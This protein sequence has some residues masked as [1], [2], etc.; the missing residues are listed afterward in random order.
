MFK[1]I[2]KW[3]YENQ[4]YEKYPIP[5]DWN[6]NIYKDNMEEIVNCAYCGKKIRVGDN[7]ESLEIRNQDYEGYIICEKCFNKEMLRR[8]H[9]K[10]R[11]YR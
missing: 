2:Q 10:E 1:L 8:K 3:N 7:Y 9:Y 6:I 4:E 5:Q 11:R